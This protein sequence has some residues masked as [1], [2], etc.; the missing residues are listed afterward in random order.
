MITKELMYQLQLQDQKKETFQMC[1]Y[2]ITCLRQDLYFHSQT[3]YGIQLEKQGR[4]GTEE[5]LM[6]YLSQKKERAAHILG[7]LYRNHVTIVDS[8]MI[9]EDILDLY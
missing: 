1:Y 4:R 3:S 8:D 9:V 2:L 7:A 6:P 5:I